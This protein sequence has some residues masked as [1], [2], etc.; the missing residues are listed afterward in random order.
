MVKLE[1]QTM[2]IELYNVILQNSYLKLQT[3]E[4]QLEL[5]DT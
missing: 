1:S 2:T 4:V 5:N 3:S